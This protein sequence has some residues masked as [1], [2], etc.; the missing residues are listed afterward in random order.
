MVE[1]GEYGPQ[2]VAKLRP[3]PLAPR[4]SPKCSTIT[5]ESV[6][7]IARARPNGI[8]A[9]NCLA[10]STAVGVERLP[11]DWKEM[12]V[13]PVEPRV[14]AARERNTPG[15][16]SAG[17]WVVK[18]RVGLGAA[19]FTPL[20]TP[21]DHALGLIIARRRPTVGLAHLIPGNRESVGGRLAGGG[22]VTHLGRHARIVVDVAVTILVQ[23]V[24]FRG[25]CR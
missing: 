21:V 10:T 1:P 15:S 18:Q 3:R 9:I 12:T 5:T 8:A 16:H 13:G 24:W 4:T 19:I 2:Q 23:E 20:G 11:R 14:S 6:D 17:T 25:G 22:Q 7:A